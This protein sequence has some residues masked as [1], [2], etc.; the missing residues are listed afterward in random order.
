MRSK[1]IAAG[2]GLFGYG[3]LIGWAATADYYQRRMED[4]E[5]T[6]RIRIDNMTKKT[7]DLEQALARAMMDLPEITEEEADSTEI[8]AE[9]VEVAEGDDEESDEEEEEYDEEKTA[10][11]RSNL[12]GIIDSYTKDDEVINSFVHRAEH[13]VT[14][15]TPPFVI[16]REQ[17]S[18]DEDEGDDYAKITLTYYP[19]ERILLDDDE[20]VIDDIN[21]YVGWRNLSQFGGESGDA[22]VVFV[23]NR[24]LQ[25]DFEVV[26]DTENQ[27]PTHVRYGMP[28]EE[29]NANKAAGLIRFRPEDT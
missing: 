25:T 18:W 15:R 22:D 13:A 12:Q 23:R 7:F 5:E 28:R 6:S 29:F 8:A 10:E 17:Y 9:I 16:S 1:L 4:R 14:D 27:P 2:V 19:R 26:R 21:A 20:E 24:R 11:L 3:A